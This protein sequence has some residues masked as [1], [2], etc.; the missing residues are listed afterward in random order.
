MHRL[1]SMYSKNR[2]KVWAII[3]MIILGLSLIQVLNKSARNKEKEA[4]MEKRENIVKGS[5][6][7]NE[8]EKD[9]QKESNTLTSNSEVS[10][11]YQV[12]FG[13]IIDDFYT[14]CIENDIE[15][16]YGLLSDDCKN[17]MYP[18]QNLFE[19]L[20]CK[21]KFSGS[22]EYSFQSWATGRYIYIYQV[23]IFDNMLSTGKASEQGYIE[24]Y[25]TLVPDEDSF[26]LN[27]NSFI[28]TK[29]IGEKSADGSLTIQANSK[30]IY[31]DYE[32]YKFKVKNNTQDK[33]LLDT[34]EKTDTMYIVDDI[35]NRYKAFSYEKSK[36]ELLIEPDET[37]IVEIKYDRAFNSQRNVEKIIFSN[38]VKYDEYLANQDATGETIYINM[39]D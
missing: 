33:I 20:Y 37:K 17:L 7:E 12:K 22:K 15:K 3:I 6:S 24:D 29:V 2:L 32:I 13:K 34:G 36:N 35:K 8:Q 9:Y 25:V 26:K 30:E 4:Q 27:V 18:N 23:K 31:K 10:E 39:D 14:A 5:N 1:I 28:G 21:G 11:K 38:I 16:A 19:S